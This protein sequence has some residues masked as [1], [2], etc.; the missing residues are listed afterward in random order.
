MSSRGKILILLLSGLAS[1]LAP[2]P[3]RAV[4]E[5]GCLFCHGLDLRSAASGRDGRDLRVWESPGG[6]HDALFCSDC[7]T[8]AR[9]APHAAAPGPAQCIGDCHGQT[10]ASKEK[11]RR[12]SF[13]GLTESHRNLS[14]PGAPC[15]ICHRAYDRA[16]ATAGIL[17]RCAGCHAGQRESEYGGVHARVSGRRGVDLCAGCHAAHPAGAVVAKATCGASG[18]HPAVTAGMMRLVGHKGRI[19]GGRASET[20]VLIGIAALGWIVGRRLTPPGRSDGERR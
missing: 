6:Y 4:D 19:A 12:A 13:G 16:G 1:L 3:A 2:A 15:R 9:R 20:G 11:H 14:S 5:E 10:G 17:E 7:H 18:C 8:D